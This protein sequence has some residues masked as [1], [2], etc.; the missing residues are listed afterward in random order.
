MPPLGVLVERALLLVVVVVAANEGERPA[1]V[2]GHSGEKASERSG[3][4]RATGWDAGADRPSAIASC[5]PA[6]GVLVG[7]AVK[8]QPLAWSGTSSDPSS[9]G[10]GSDV[11]GISYVA[12]ESCKAAEWKLCICERRCSQ[13]KRKKERKKMSAMGRRAFA[14]WSRSKGRKTR[15]VL[16]WQ[17]EAST[18]TKE[19]RTRQRQSH[20]HLQDV[21]P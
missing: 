14:S 17:P 8:W 13:T 4:D 1:H 11:H 5:L 7:V 3:G 20:A 16:Q 9:E 21:E 10:G 15:M 18:T 19:Q 12:V 2:G 6:V